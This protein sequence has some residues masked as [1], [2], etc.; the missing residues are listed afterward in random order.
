MRRSPYAVRILFVTPMS[1]LRANT[2]GEQRSALLYQ[3][4][5][6]WGQ[7]DIIE[8]AIGQQPEITRVPV[9]GVRMIY[10]V[11]AGSKWRLNLFQPK[12]N[13]TLPLEDA[14]GCS[15]SNYDLVVGRYVW[16]VCQLEIPKKVPVVV[17]LDDFY[18]RK[19]KPI[20]WTWRLL[21]M[22]IKRSVNAV[23]NR[24]QL[25]RFVGA[26]FPSQTDFASAAA[27]GIRFKHC[28]VAPNIPYHSVPRQTPHHDANKHRVLF[29][30]NLSYPPNH[31]GVDWFV[32]MVWP[33]VLRHIPSAELT[34]VGAG[35]PAVL[36]TWASNPN[37]HTPG[38]VKNL[39]DEYA[40]TSVVVVPVWY[41]AG[42][43]I[44]LLEAL[45][46]GCACVASQTALA[47]FAE[48]LRDGVELLA[49]KD[50]D[51]FASQ[52]IK[53]LLNAQLRQSLAEA[54][55]QKVCMEFN[56]EVFGTAIDSLLKG[57]FSRPAPTPGSL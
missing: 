20:P 4:L 41:G 57:I 7:V 42:S 49:A 28:L 14:L 24:F 21:K 9:S 54:G 32:K 35:S 29:V 40:K 38:F 45:A 2:G 56:R 5:T 34:L 16:P 37:V 23:G 55:Q 12:K 51:S 10:V 6:Q 3:T 46:Q 53:C 44:K 25:K 19:G 17:D 1:P 13:L 22:A 18:F 36:K 26:I 39:G 47:P 8:I 30:G 33:T 52:V 15:F 48:A 31:D 50:A 43:N 27:Q 11:V